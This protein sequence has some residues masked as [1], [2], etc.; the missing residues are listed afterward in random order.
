VVSEQQIAPER[1]NTTISLPC[2]SSQLN[3]TK[4][5]GLLLKA[6]LLHNVT[7]ITVRC[8]TVVWRVVCSEGGGLCDVDW[9]NMLNADV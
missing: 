4:K 7:F 2:F 5:F 3:H 1:Y 6:V 8:A 9:L